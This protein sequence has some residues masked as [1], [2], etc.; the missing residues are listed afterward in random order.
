MRTLKNIMGISVLTLFHT[1]KK[2]GDLSLKALE[3]HR[4]ITV[5]MKN[6]RKKLKVILNK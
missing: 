1:D 2:K 4:L 3:F 6:Y 5:V